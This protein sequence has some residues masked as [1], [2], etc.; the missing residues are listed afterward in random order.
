M[1][2]IPGTITNYT[3]H[4]D[5]VAL[6]DLSPEERAAAIK[7]SKVAAAQRKVNEAQ[8]ELRAVQA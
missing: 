7:A 3:E 8:A 1:R 6:L 4:E 2:S 5:Q